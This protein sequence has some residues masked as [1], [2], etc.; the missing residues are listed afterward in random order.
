MEWIQ[1][2]YNAIISFKDWIF[3]VLSYVFDIFQTIFYGAVSLLSWLYDI[4]VEFLHLS[5]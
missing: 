3:T 5:L 2:I 4:I 1:K